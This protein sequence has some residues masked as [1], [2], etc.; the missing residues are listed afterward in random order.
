M[1][2]KEEEDEDSK[3]EDMDLVDDK[4]KKKK[5]WVLIKSVNSKILL[6]FLLNANHSDLW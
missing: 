6:F 5:K 4:I 3:I 1:V 2:K